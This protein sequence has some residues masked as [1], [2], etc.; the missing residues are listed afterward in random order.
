MTADLPCGRIVAIVGSKLPL[1][2]QSGK[3]LAH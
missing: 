3:R 2:I 1:E